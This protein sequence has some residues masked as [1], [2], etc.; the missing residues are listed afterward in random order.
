MRNYVALLRGINV[1][2]QKKIKMTDL[3]NLM[4]IVGFV[5]VDTYIQSGNI[6]F[7]YESNRTESVAKII[8]KSI[9]TKYGFDVP[10]IILTPADLKNVLKNNPWTNDTTKDPNRTYVTFLAE[11][12]LEENL[13]KILNL[14]YSP[15]EYIID[16]KIIYFFSPAGYGRAKMNNNFFEKKLKVIAT[17][18]NWKT[19][20]KLLELSGN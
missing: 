10:A 11:T 2:G 20:V 13:S 17:T 1:S 12:P 18:R 3:K 15:E 19:V 9:N 4:E 5:N 14:D 16:G 6:I 7:D 8:E